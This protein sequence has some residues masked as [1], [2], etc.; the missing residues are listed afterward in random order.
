M[1]AVKFFEQKLDELGIEI[2]YIIFKQALEL[3]K[4]QI[5]K[6]YLSGFNDGILPLGHEI[7]QSAEQ[8]YETLKNETK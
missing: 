1:T 8:Y 6:S 2:P 7:F 3:E 4:Q 5:I